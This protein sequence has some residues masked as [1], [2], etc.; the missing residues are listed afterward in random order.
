[1]FWS[2]VYLAAASA[3]APIPQGNA[4]VHNSPVP[5]SHIAITNKK[6]AQS[7]RKAS[8]I[9]SL[10]FNISRSFVSG[11][12]YSSIGS[13]SESA[14]KFYSQ[15]LHMIHSVN[16]YRSKG[17]PVSPCHIN[18]GEGVFFPES[19]DASIILSYGILTDPDANTAFSDS[20]ENF[21]SRHTSFVS[22]ILSDFISRRPLKSL[23]AFSSGKVVQ[24]YT[25]PDTDSVHFISLTSTR[26][27]GAG[28]SMNETDQ[29][30][31]PEM[32]KNHCKKAHFSGKFS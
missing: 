2:G 24:L 30:F 16:F 27:R 12:Q 4:I 7:Y 14:G 17:D 9:K 25:L 11:I 31:R 1:M 26:D 6:E 19:E 21:I 3:V 20:Y 32:G 15:S 18:P 29:R 10:Y 23:S 13:E 8:E 28:R 22:A 5:D